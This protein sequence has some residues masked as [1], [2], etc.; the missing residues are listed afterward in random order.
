MSQLNASATSHPSKPQSRLARLALLALGLI[1]VG[2]AHAANTL[3]G[4]RTGAVASRSNQVAGLVAPP[5]PLAVISENF[6]AF[7]PGTPENANCLTT[8]LGAGW[9]LK[10]NSSPT[11]A[12]CVFAQNL[13]GG[14]P[15]GTP[16][17]DPSGFYAGMNFNSTSGV[18][19]ISTWMV[20]P[21]VNF[22]PTSVLRF[23]ARFAAAGFADRLQIRISTS[24]T[25]TSVGTTAT[26]VGDFT[27][28]VLDINPTLLAGFG[29]CPSSAITAAGST[30]TGN[31]NAWCNITISGAALPTSGSGRIAFRYFVTNGGTGANSDFIGIDTFSFDEGT[32]CPSTIVTNG[33]DSGAGSLRQIIANACPG[34]TITFQSGVSTV[35]LTTAELAINKNLTIDGGSSL[36]TVARIRGGAISF[37]PRGSTYAL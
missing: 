32:P 35:T 1:S 16:A 3:T 9:F 15:F 6:N 37:V 31:L 36:V 21:Q 24:G 29:T 14:G 11:G 22:T 26:D 8:G 27:S 2:A 10:N 13:A 20:S 17:T 25:S 18:G 5:A 7:A 23:A 33:G 34:S 12:T 28:L 30:I 4:S 19:T